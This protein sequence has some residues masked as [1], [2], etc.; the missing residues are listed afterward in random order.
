MADDK[1]V[2]I[3]VFG[4]G[5]W[6]RFQISAWRE[7][8]GVQIVALYNRTKSKAQGVAR[9]FGIPAVYDDPQKLL[10]EVEVDA[11]DII[12]DVDTHPKFLKL[13]AQKQKGRTV[14]S[15]KPMAPDIRQCVEMVE[16]CRKAG[17][18]FYV[19][20]N[21][22]HQAPLR[23]LKYILDSGEIGKVFRARMDFMNGFPVFGN[24]PFLRELKQFILTDIGS[25][26]FDATRFLFGEA[27]SLY[28]QTQK[29]HTNIQGEDVATALLDMG[30]KVVTCHM[31]YAENHHEHECFPQTFVFVEGTKG[32]AYLGPD[33]WIRVTTAQ[34]TLSR[35]FKPPRYAWADPQYDL[36]HA[37]IAAC[38][39]DLLAGLRG[40]RV[41]ETTG[42]DNLKTMRLVYGAY[43]SSR[44]KRPIDPAANDW[45]DASGV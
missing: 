9:E 8:P 32:T 31:A 42:E 33:Y 19:H 17:V 20:E 23:A 18:R 5:F 26:I 14:I 38:N 21:W 28:C 24:Q 36:V 6:S 12:T 22:R 29:I 10:D 37:S 15:Q 40:E 16:T 41:P 43:A 2:R 13:A 35:Q 3:A 4:A 7:Y 11:V 44:L 39:A 27:R 25:H 30:D 1:P 34:G 45:F